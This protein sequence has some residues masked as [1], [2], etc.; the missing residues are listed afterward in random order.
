MAGWSVDVQPRMIASLKRRV[1][2]AG[3]ASRVHAR[4]GSRGTMGLS[5]LAGA[6]DFTLAFAVVHE[7]PAAGPFFEEVAATSKAGATLLFA[8]PAGH[9]KPEEFNAELQAALQ[10]GFVV[11][12]HP[13]I[14]RSRAVL[15][16]KP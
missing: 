16:R 5:Y 12:A 14:R 15:L 2:R 6:V 8:E 10:A 3:L 7:L 9:V 4:I 13:P 11:T 1:L